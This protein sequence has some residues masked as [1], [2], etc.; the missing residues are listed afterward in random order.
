ME[1]GKR[2]PERVAVVI[3]VPERERKVDSHMFQGA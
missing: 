1:K 2:R 3:R